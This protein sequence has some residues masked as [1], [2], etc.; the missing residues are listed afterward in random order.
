MVVGR[1][2]GGW[3][4]FERPRNRQPV[5]TAQ[6]F[7]RFPD[8]EHQQNFVDCIRSRQRPNADVETAN[9]S[10]LLA[11][12]ANISHRLGGRKLVIDADT[13]EISGDPDAMKLYRRETYREPWGL[14]RSN[15]V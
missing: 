14:G 12:F 5:V 2:G 10:M 6:Q 11:H 1:M 3:Q 13:A 4:V 8:A 9:R 15:D 7:G